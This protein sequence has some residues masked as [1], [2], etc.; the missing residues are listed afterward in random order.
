M[1]HPETRN[2]IF[3]EQ[4]KILMHDNY[5]EKQYVLRLHA[6]QT[7]AHACPGSF[8]HLQCD[9]ELLMRRPMSI[10]RANDKAGWID[11][12][13][14]AHGDGTSRLSKKKLMIL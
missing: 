9:S 12:L 11:I 4:A 2:T 14:K 5:A 6:P 13:Y 3:V 8:I 10:M 1:P 7:A